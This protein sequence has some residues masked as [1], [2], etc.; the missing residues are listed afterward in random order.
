MQVGF[1]G[2]NLDN[3]DVNKLTSFQST[4]LGAD[5]GFVYEFRPGAEKFKLDGDKWRKDLN[6][7]KL[8]LGVALLDIGSISYQ[9]D[10]QR[11][12]GYDISI[13]G[14]EKLD[15]DEI[16]NTGLDQLKN[17]FDSR[18]QFFTP[19]AGTSSSNYKVSLPTTLHIDADYHFH[20]GFYVNL[21]GQLS[22]VNAKDNPYNSQY[23]SSFSIT[24]RYEGLGIGI[25]VPVNYNALTNFN[26]GLSL[27]FKSLFIGSGSVLTA[28][29]GDS[30]QADIYMGIRVGGLQKNKSK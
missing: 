28:L 6:K 19:I 21:A 11:S 27:R 25:Y 9:R 20:K 2:I 29:L 3:F 13:T 23:Y 5:I 12:G 1:G 14:S 22:L 10:V 30:K 8:R 17:Y 7:Y 4:G 16:S 15:M 18:P 24:P 26:A